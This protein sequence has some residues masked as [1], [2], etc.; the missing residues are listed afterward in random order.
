MYCR[1]Q[2]NQAF[3]DCSGVIGLVVFVVIH[4]A[5]ARYV[6]SLRLVSLVQGK[7]MKICFLHSFSLC[8]A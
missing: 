8:F 1:D 6:V 5:Y 3:K 4:L 2:R 7:P